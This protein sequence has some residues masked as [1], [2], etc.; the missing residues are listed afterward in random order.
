LEQSFCEVKA[1]IRASR[2][3]VSD[4]RRGGFSI[5]S[6]RNGLEAETALHLC[7]I[8]GHSEISVCMELSTRAGVACLDVVE[9]PPGIGK[10]TLEGGDIPGL[11]FRN[12]VVAVEQISMRTSEGVDRDCQGQERELDEVRE[13]DYRNKVR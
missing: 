6:H 13:H 3:G 12:V 5:I 4:R 1:S 2:A 7:H 10:A 9:G 8:H 11:A